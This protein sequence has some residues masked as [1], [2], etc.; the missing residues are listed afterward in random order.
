MA[1]FAASDV[2][3]IFASDA[4]HERGQKMKQ[5][6]SHH[7]RGQAALLLCAAW[8]A[9]APLH[10]AHADEFDTLRAK[11]QTRLTGGTAIDTGDAD[12]AQAIA[13]QTANAQMHWDAMNKGSTRTA[14]WNDLASASVSSHVT[15]SY[16][17]LYTMAAAYTTTGSAL[18]GNA[19][20][21]AD[22]VA[23]LDW[24]H[25][26]RYNPSITYYDNWWDWHIGTPQSLT[27]IVTLMYGQLTAQQRADYLGAIDKFVPDPAVRLKPDGTVL[28]VE[29]GANLLDKSLAVVLRGVL[30]KSPA[31]VTQ[32]RDAISPGLRYVTSGDGFYRDGSF[33]QHGNIAYT[34]SYGPAVID[35]MSKLLYLL[36]G[37]TWAFTDPNVANVYDWA[38][39]AFRPL[40]HD[41][42]MMDSVRGRGIAREFSTDHTAGRSVVTALVRLTQA[43]AATNPEHSATLNAA[44]KGWMQRDTTFGANYY[45]PTPTAVAGVYSPLPLYE[46][47]LLKALA[48]DGDVAP[49]A[50]PAGAHVFAGMDRAIHRAAF[51]GADF[52]ASL[53]MFSNRISA[54]EY[55][56]GENLAGWWTGMGML[57]LYNADLTQYDN[58]YWPTVNRLR[59]P[60]TT[61]D[62]SGSGT[63]VAWKSYP[64]TKNWVGGAA[65][66]ERHAAVGMEFATAA[67]TG[68]SLTGRK[69][70]FMFGDRIVA[71]G[72]GIASSDNV[73]VE[74]IVDNRK[75]NAGGSNALTVN[76]TVQSSANGST[77]LST[78][79]WAHLAGTVAGADLAWYFPDAPAVNALRETRTSSW[80]AMSSGGSTAAVSNS[81]LSLALP[82]GSNPTAGTYS[83]VILPGRSAAQAAAYAAAPTVTVLERSAGATAVRD[84]A[85]GLVGANFWQDAVKTVSV[86]GA[87]WLTSNRKA[88]V[89]TQ[90]ADNVLQVAVADPTQANTGTISLEIARAAG[91]TIAASSGVT[92]TQ[93]SPTIKLTVDVKA[94]AGKSFTA[95][96]RLMRQAVLRPAA[97]ATVRDG[98]YAT[99]NYG[100]TATMAVKQDGAGYA[101]QGLVRFDL[102]SLGGTIGAATLQ[103]APRF[104]GQ[105]SA[106]THNIY[107]VAD[108]W[109]ETAVTWNTRPAD[110]ALLGSWSVPALNT[111]ATLG[112]TAAARSAY[113]SDRLLSFRI[114]AATN[115]GANGWVEYS[116]RENGTAPLPALVVDYY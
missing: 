95:S 14:L 50:E 70:W 52:G 89:L 29:T 72:A 38:V 116:T 111:Y 13:T 35:D 63:P 5:P 44:I 60:G 80:K 18:K 69:S 78:V 97:D 76:G 8:V 30:G 88:A 27:N 103:L 74:T 91:A 83:Y 16:G 26:N 34:G 85:L 71:V 23:A 100:G 15:N 51:G 22:I 66:N 21:A 6:P 37:S 10:A 77:S 92:V 17:R 64:N 107:Q 28:T 114:E 31:K 2:N 25:A 48:A 40:I 87:P 46:M 24:M 82:H 94:A 81:F 4:D 101:R 102:S 56:N 93:L 86:G 7:A 49:A 41:G 53:A 112:V 33:I 108:S 57:T 113:E 90:E 115:Y 104:L 36:T 105:T 68:T 79:R 59:L 42:A 20:L 61:T 99:V 55:G 1:F 62:R 54:F 75:L 84:T 96:F 65:L 47:A 43:G 12:I 3:V 32:G 109:S 73:A 45:A 58:H 67:V 9:L 98:S 11:W 106:M 110:T 39:D 19:A